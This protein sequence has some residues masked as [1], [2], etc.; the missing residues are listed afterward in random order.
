MKG[1]EDLKPTR[2]TGSVQFSALS[3]EKPTSAHSSFLRCFARSA[4][5]AFSLN[6]AVVDEVLDRTGG[7]GCLFSFGHCKFPFG[8]RISGAVVDLAPR[9]R[10]TPFSR[11]DQRKN[12]ITMMETYVEGWEKQGR[13]LIVK[14]SKGWYER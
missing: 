9:K 5:N 14:R 1:G 12:M 2:T 11:S 13:S 7:Q 8:P 4:L 10:R 6:D 3:G